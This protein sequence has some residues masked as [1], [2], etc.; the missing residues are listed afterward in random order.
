MNR[1]Y[2]KWYSNRLDRNMELLVF[3]HAGLPVLVFPTSGGRFFEFEDRNMIS[4]V[5][6]RIERGDE[7]RPVRR[8]VALWVPAARSVLPLATLARLAYL[9]AARAPL[10]HARG[11]GGRLERSLDS[12][13]VRTM[14][15][16][17]EKASPLECCPGL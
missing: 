5:G 12:A 6:E 17:H 16:S 1:E 14:P 9:H 7:S 3:G 4:A 13:F 2:H 8:E 10:S 11:S 15:I